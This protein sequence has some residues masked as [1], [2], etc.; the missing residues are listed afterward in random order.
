MHGCPAPSQGAAPGHGRT[1]RDGKRRWT[2]TH[3]AWIARRRIDDD[4]AHAALGQMPVHLDGL[5]RHLDALDRDIETIAR[6]ERRKG[7]VEI[8]TE[9]RGIATQPARRRSAPTSKR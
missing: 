4:L 7:V 2:K 6:C 9:L 3:R 5:D 1:Y 8:L